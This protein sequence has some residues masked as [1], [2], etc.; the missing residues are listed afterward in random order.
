MPSRPS[1]VPDAI[2][3][4]VLWRI[5]KTEY[6]IVVKDGQHYNLIVDPG[7]NQPWHTSNKRRADQVAH[8][9]DGQAMLLEDA[10]K[11]LMKHNLGG[12]GGLEKHLI[13]Q[14]R[15]PLVRKPT[16]LPPD[17]KTITDSHGNPII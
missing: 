2:R 1:R 5:A 9:A 16:A 12:E 10:F 15:K 8:E 11:F 13:E 3:D 14:M 6:V 17:N 7:M 4:R